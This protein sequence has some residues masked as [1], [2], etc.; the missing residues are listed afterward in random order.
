MDLIFQIFGNKS[1][2]NK[3]VFTLIVLFIYRLGTHV[4]I[5]G[6]DLDK[7]QQLFSQGG[8][9][10][11]FNL[12][13]GGG[14]ERFSIFALGILPF[15]NASIVIQLLTYAFPSFKEL[16]E[17]GESGRKQLSQY[18]RYLTFFISLFQSFVMVVSLKSLILD[19]MSPIIFMTVSVISLVVGSLLVMWFG[20]II[21]ES[22]FGN[23]ASL[24][25]FIG[26]VSQMPKYVQDTYLLIVGGVNPINVIILV[27]AIIFMIISIVYFQEADRK[28]PVQY[29]KRVVGRRMVAGQNTFIPLRLIQGG[30]MPII[31]A[32]AVLQFPMMIFQYFPYEPI[33]NFFNTYYTYDGFFYNG[34]FCVLIFFF[35]YFYTAISFNPVDL[36]DNIKKHGG[37]VTGVRPGQ[38]TIDFFENIIS[39]LTLVGASFL[40][41]IALLPIL[42]ATVTNVTSFIGLGA[43]ALL[44]IVGVAMDLVRQLEMSLI[45][46]KYEKNKY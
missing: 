40:A 25:I 46:S 7:V 14:L 8:I 43:T 22:G 12:F 16:A 10:G 20:E 11:F 1:L 9:L 18:T 26:I 15:I 3:V 5:H 2:R 41:T 31:F 35:T 23:G 34:F 44:I 32:S 33:Q 13:S 21:S 28:V 19:S 39:K 36:A 42:A 38:A 6:I 30:V 24:L 27:L 29:A 45:A 4:P 37:F 17:E